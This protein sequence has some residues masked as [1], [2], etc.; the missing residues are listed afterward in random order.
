MQKGVNPKNLG[1]TC[2]IGWI[3][4]R[5]EAKK[6]QKK[7]TVNVPVFSSL[8]G[9]LHPFRAAPMGSSRSHSTSRVQKGL[10]WIF[11]DFIAHSVTFICETWKRAQKR[12]SKKATV[13]NPY[14]QFVVPR[15]GGIK[16]EGDFHCCLRWARAGHCRTTWRCPLTGTAG[17]DP[18]CGATTAFENIKASLSRC[19]AGTSR[20]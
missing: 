4:K 10:G 15:R 14:E 3:Q 18:I 1:P 5:K 16:S 20:I 11:L 17:R 7:A 8:F 9:S 12:T 2:D 13:N 19:R 6:G